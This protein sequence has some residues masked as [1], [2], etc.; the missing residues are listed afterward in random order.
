ML[1]ALLARAAGW[2]LET[3]LRERIFDPLGMAKWSRPPAFPDA[4]GG[5]VSTVNYYLTFARLLLNKGRPP[6]PAAPIRSAVAISSSPTAAAIR[7]SRSSA[8]K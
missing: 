7:T 8:T 2:P 4:S 3:F 5:L 1:S 6:R